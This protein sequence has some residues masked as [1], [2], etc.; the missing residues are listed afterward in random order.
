LRTCAK[1]HPI[2]NKQILD[3]EIPDDSFMVCGKHLWLQLSYLA[4]GDE[5]G[6]QVTVIIVQVGKQGL[7]QKDS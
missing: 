2:N 4:K 3:N 5:N 7:K 1:T 6:V